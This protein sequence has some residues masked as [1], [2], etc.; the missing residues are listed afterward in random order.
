MAQER[1]RDAFLGVWTLKDNS[2]D[3]E[4]IKSKG[5]Y[6]IIEFV[7]L[8]H[9]LFFSGD[10]KRVMYYEWGKGEPGLIGLEIGDGDQTITMF[11]VS[12]TFEWVPSYV[13]YKKP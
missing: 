1:G 13:F 11:G 3:I 4:I 10:G 5:N 12:D 7:H 6:Y 8:K 2:A 9:E